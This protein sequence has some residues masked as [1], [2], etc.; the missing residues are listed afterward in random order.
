[1][2]LVI[3]IL[4]TIVSIV[5]FILLTP[6]SLFFIL[7][8]AVRFG[9]FYRRISYSFLAFATAI[10]IAG[11]TAFSGFLNAFCLKKGGY[12]FGSD[13]SETISSVFGKNL[14]L[15]KLTYLGL[16]FAG[17]LDTIDKDHCIKSINDDKFEILPYQKVGVKTKV[18]SFFLFITILL[19]SYKLLSLI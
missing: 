2:K 9:S 13:R 11:N 15:N 3:N 17:V 14:V 7:Y 4:L 6:I 16:G 1:M 10:D 5:L 18:V 8:D 12:H 19:L